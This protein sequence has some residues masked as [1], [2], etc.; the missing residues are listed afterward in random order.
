MNYWIVNVL[1]FNKYFY[2]NRLALLFK[3]SNELLLLFGRISRNDGRL[4]W[5]KS[6]IIL[7]SYDGCF[8]MFRKWINRREIKI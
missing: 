7:W 3:C 8:K 2:R 6:I 5:N 1:N 4:E